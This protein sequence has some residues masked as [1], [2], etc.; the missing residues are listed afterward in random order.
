MKTA[1]RVVYIAETASDGSCR[2]MFRPMEVAVQLA[3]EGWDVTILAAT[4]SNQWPGR[5]PAGA[6]RFRNVKFVRLGTPFPQPNGVKRAANMI[7]FALKAGAFLF[8]R[9]AE[10]RPAIVVTAS[11]GFLDIFPAFLAA[12][13][14]GYQWIFEVRDVWPDSPRQLNPKLRTYGLLQMA[15]FALKLAF[16]FA[17]GMMSTLPE[18]GKLLRERGRRKEMD[19]LLVPNCARLNTVP[20]GTIPQVSTAS[21]AAEGLARLR[22]RFAQVVGYYGSFNSGNGTLRLLQLAQSPAMAGV[23]FLFVG[24]GGDAAEV[25]IFASAHDNIR[26]AP[27][28]DPAECALLMRDTDVLLIGLPWIPALRYGLS[29]I[30]YADYLLAGRPLFCWGA[31]LGAEEDTHGHMVSAPYTEATES[32][33]ASLR[34]MLSRGPAQLDEMGKKARERARSHYTYDAYRQRIAT[35]FSRRFNPEGPAQVTLAKDPKSGLIPWQ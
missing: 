20:G 19:L 12:L 22:S 28:V 15:S 5:L 35:F 26:I 29:P 16:R 7:I 10:L 25:R 34:E 1:G 21:E 8:R 3:Q 2:G 31:S 23:G 14:G 27:P 4:A 11:T 30:K 32:A 9:R 6:G 18:S 24:E 17:H 33:A 13:T